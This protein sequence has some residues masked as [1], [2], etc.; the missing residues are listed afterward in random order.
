VE[1]SANND[2]G[3]NFELSIKVLSSAPPL[4]AR[5]NKLQVFIKILH[6]VVRILSTAPL[7]FKLLS[8]PLKD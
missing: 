7:L 2:G 4:H 1:I 8:A 6:L 3:E 5:S